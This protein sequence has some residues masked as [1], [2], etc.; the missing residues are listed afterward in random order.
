MP[1]GSGPG[2]TARAMNPATRPMSKRPM[3]KRIMTASFRWELS[4]RSH[5]GEPSD[6]LPAIRGGELELPQDP[7]V[8]GIERPAARTEPSPHGHPNDE[9]RRAPHPRYHD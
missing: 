5:R 6:A 2:T 8:G 9:S 7:V 1:M 3:M 4:G